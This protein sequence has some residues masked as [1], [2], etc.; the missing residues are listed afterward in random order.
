MPRSTSGMPLSIWL[1]NISSD[2][3]LEE[4]LKCVGT[5]WRAASSGEQYL[6]SSPFPSFSASCFPFL[7]DICSSIYL[8]L[9]CK[10]MVKY[11]LTCWHLN[12]LLFSIQSLNRGFW[13][14]RKQNLPRQEIKFWNYHTQELCRPIKLSR[15]T[16]SLRELVDCKQIFYR[17]K[18]RFFWVPLEIWK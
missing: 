15:V 4:A 9:E 7:F 10:T 5:A 1:D 8:I 17:C 14:H 18:L 3:C 2:C 12:L 6:L 11:I 13:P 16:F